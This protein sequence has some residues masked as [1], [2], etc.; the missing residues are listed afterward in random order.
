M[1][2]VEFFSIPGTNYGH[3]ENATIASKY[4]FF[5]FKTTT[6]SLNTGR[7]RSQN[8]RWRAHHIQSSCEFFSCTLYLTVDQVLWTFLLG[9]SPFAKENYTKKFGHIQ[10]Q[11]R[12]LRLFRSLFSLHHLQLHSTTLSLVRLPSNSRPQESHRLRYC[13]MLACTALLK[14]VCPT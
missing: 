9:W 5:S 10:Q 2:N 3:L 7:L 14:G 11:A 8:A 1:H 12:Q 13:A 6:L 4:K